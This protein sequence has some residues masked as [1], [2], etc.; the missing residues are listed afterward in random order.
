M[1]APHVATRVAAERVRVI[2]TLAERGIVKPDLTER[3][4]SDLEAQGVPHVAAVELVALGKQRGREAAA[5]A[6]EF[7]A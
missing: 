1:T 4:V 7:G 5:A 3:L 2:V 6:A